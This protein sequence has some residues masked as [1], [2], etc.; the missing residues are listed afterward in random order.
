MIACP[1]PKTEVEVYQTLGIWHK[2]LIWLS[3]KVLI[4]L[5]KYPQS[6]WF[7]SDSSYLHMTALHMTALLLVWEIIYHPGVVEY[8]GIRPL[9][10][11]TGQRV[12]SIIYEPYTIITAR[13]RPLHAPLTPCT[14][15]FWRMAL[16]DIVYLSHGQ[17]YT[18][19]VS[20]SAAARSSYLGLTHNVCVLAL[21]EARRGINSVLSLAHPPW[22]TLANWQLEDRLVVC[23]CSLSTTTDIQLARRLGIYTRKYQW[24]PADWQSLEQSY[25]IAS[26]E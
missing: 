23:K 24:F 20:L 16:C 3:A 5:I 26:R 1:I 12:I 18:P 19:I 9:V 25:G 11:S 2:H 15:I 8:K 7:P 22:L 14:I 17:R 6:F 21:F 10:L 13:F 4:S